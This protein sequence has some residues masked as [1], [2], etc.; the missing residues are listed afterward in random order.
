[1]LFDD[2][3]PAHVMEKVGWNPGC[4]TVDPAVDLSGGP[5]KIGSVVPGQKI[6]LVRNPLWWGQA[7][8]LK[9]MTIRI[10]AG[11]GQ[12]THWL[13]TGTAQVVQPSTFGPPLLEQITQQPSENSSLTVSATFLQLEYS[14]TSAITGDLAVRQAISHAVN[15]QDLVNSVVGWAD[16]L[17]RPLGH[18][19]L[20]ADPSQ[21]PR[22]E[23]PVPG[24]G[25]P[26][27]DDH[28]HHTQPADVVPAVP[29]HLR[30]GPDRPFAHLGGLRE[31]AN[32]HMG[33][34]Q[35]EAPRS[36]P[37]RR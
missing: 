28:H 18:A 31:G 36:H 35:R 21:L 6:V 19:P 29:A 30:P 32:R 37:G 13:Q 26:A 23:D 14:T 33:P 24:T 3:L 4:T 20:L 22:T 12:L 27:R 8:N 10:A 34:A 11:P 7:A 1:M 15:R 25:R 16:D 9:Q 2:L 17:Y 5:F